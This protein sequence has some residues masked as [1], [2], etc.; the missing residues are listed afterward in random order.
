VALPGAAGPTV[1]AAILSI[2]DWPW[3]FAINL[4]IGAIVLLASRALPRIP[5]SRRR[6]DRLSAGLNAVVFAALVVGVDLLTS[7][8]Q[9]GLCLLAGAA[10]CLGL[11][12]HRELPQSAPLIP[13]DLLRAGSFRISIIASVFC[14][15]G[16]TASLVSLPFYLSHVFGQS[17]FMTGLY[18]TPWPL[19]V[20][21]AAPISGRLSGRIPTA[22][23]CA[24]GGACLSLGLALS[25]LWPPGPSPLTLVPFTILSG[26]G[27][28]FF[29]TP[30]NRNML[31]SAPKARSGAAGG[32]Q[33]TARLL[34]QT[35]GGVIM[36]VLFTLASAEMAPRIGLAIGAALALAAGVVSTLRSGRAEPLAGG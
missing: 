29:Q 10:L 14:F 4:P 15:M 23:L 5:G 18:M 2:A 13:I 36:T 33:G 3:L 27:F 20:A 34:G 22:W 31:L 24:A 35:L 1:G 16:Q 8:L 21:L 7:H 30:N 11:L 26:L 17:A 32:M 25:A 12:I 19:T 28:G 6:I 9:V